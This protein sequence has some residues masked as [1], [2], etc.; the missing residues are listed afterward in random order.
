MEATKKKRLKLK[1]GDIFTIPIDDH[2]HGY[3][4]IVKIPDRYSFI[5]IVF[6]GRW[7]NDEIITIDMIVQ[8]KVLFLGF[9]TDALL[10]HGKWVII[11][12]STLNLSSIVM[13]YFKLG[14]PLESQSLVN[15][16]LHIIRP[17][18]SE[19]AKLLSYH[20]SASPIGY[21]KALQAYYGLIEYSFE[22]QFHYKHITETLSK[23]N[24]LVN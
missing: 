21:Q 14:L 6:E 12:N 16:N 17:A 1:E 23:L 15:Y 9:T 18:T 19:E 22:P 4:Q 8:N 10:Y 24:L 20:S 7:G 11:G 2:T 3:G 13:P 5:M